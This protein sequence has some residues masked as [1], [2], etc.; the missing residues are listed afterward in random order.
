MMTNGWPWVIHQTDTAKL[1]EWQ[2]E[3]KDRQ[4]RGGIRT[5]VD[6]DGHFG[7]A[8]VQFIYIKTIHVNANVAILPKLQINS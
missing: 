5:L 3:L 1:R 7:G 6:G 8:K 4:T 2:N